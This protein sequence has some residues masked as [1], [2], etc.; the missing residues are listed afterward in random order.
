MIRLRDPISSISHLLGAFLS[1]FGLTL[2]LIKEVKKPYDP[3]LLVASII[4]C[5]CML[6]L[7]L[8]SGIY[9]AIE[10]NYSS[11]ILFMRKLDHSMIFVLIAGSYSPFCLYVLK[12]RLGNRIFI[13]LWMIAALGIFLKFYLKQMPRVL[14]TLMYIAMG[15][16][17]IFVIKDLYLNLN[18]IAFNLLF[19]GGL[20]YTIGGIIYMVKKPNF[21]TWT[22]HDIFHIFIMLGSLSHFI[23]VYKFL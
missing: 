6:A 4:F 13:I 9:H 7:Y 22:F 2:I 23:L 14:S 10:K 19:L 8:T 12:G 1:L 5:L 21:K 11:K 15:W 17:S 20:M 3:Y 16:T 18:T